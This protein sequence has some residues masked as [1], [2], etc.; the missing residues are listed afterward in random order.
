MQGKFHQYLFGVLCAILVSFGWYCASTPHNHNP[1][2]NLHAVKHFDRQ[3][4]S[5]YDEIKV[6]RKSKRHP[7]EKL[8]AYFSE[9]DNENDDAGSDSN[10]PN[11]FALSGND[12]GNLIS[13]IHPEFHNIRTAISLANSNQLT[14]RKNA[15][16]IQYSVFRL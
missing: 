9:N 6:I 16:Y 14:S 12:F 4:K 5:G 8:R 1:S 11:L 13:Y 3:V 7:H 2:Y 10:S 15:L